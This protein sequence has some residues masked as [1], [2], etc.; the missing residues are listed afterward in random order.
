MKIWHEGGATEISHDKEIYTK[1]EDGSFE[2][3]PQV[4]E[5]VRHAG[6]TDVDPNPAPQLPPQGPGEELAL[7]ESLKRK[8]NKGEIAAYA[9]EAF[10]VDLD[11]NAYT[12]DELIVAVLDLPRQKAEAEAKEAKA[13]RLGELLAK[14]P[15]E[16][17]LEEGE[18]LAAL[19]SEE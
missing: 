19:Q 7:E 8:K 14:A 10:G 1:Q 16:L 15:E 4:F 17:T 3:P 5:A 11:P 2:V 18:E 12:R 13:A 6:F 9:K